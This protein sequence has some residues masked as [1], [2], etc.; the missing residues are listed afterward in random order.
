MQ[1]VEDKLDDSGTRS[2]ALKMAISES[3]HG[4]VKFLICLRTAHGFHHAMFQS[5][6]RKRQKETE[7]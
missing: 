1:V 4:H 6:K 5:W 3:A 7:A 2:E